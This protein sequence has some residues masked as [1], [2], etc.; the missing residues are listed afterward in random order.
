MSVRS[1]LQ[2]LKDRTDAQF[3]LFN[4]TNLIIQIVLKLDERGNGRV[5]SVTECERYPTDFLDASASDTMDGACA[6]VAFL[7]W[8]VLH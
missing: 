6:S 3:R 7:L 8:F 2:F 4:V 1:A 5:M